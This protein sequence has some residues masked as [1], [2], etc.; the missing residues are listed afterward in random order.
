MRVNDT[1]RTLVMNDHRTLEHAG[2][3]IIATGHAEKVLLIRSRCSAIHEKRFLNLLRIDSHRDMLDSISSE[4]ARIF[5]SIL[6]VHLAEFIPDTLISVHLLT[7]ET[8][9]SRK[10]RYMKKERG[11]Q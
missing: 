2:L 10:T 6:S 4:S 11:Y 9:L 5:V 8:L 3:M 7:G 1:C